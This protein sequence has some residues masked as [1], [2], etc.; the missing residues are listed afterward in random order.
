MN[1][2]RDAILQFRGIVKEFPGVK[3]LKGIDLDLYEG[4]V[5]VLVGANGAGKSTLVK[6]L[7]GVYQPDAGE[8]ILD[9]KPVTMKNPEVALALG[10]SIVYQNFNL[11]SKMDVGQNIFLTREPLKG[12][13]IKRIDWDRIYSETE[14]I[15]RRLNLNIDGRTKVKELS[16]ADL[17]MIEIAK[18]LSVKSRILVLDEPTS[19]LSTQEINELFNRIS[20]LRSEG[21][22]ILYI[23]HRLEEIKQI[24]DRVSVFRDGE[25]VGTGT[26]K[27]M[28]LKKIIKMMI[29]REI[30]NIYPW[31]SR[32]LGEEI[33]AIEK[34]T[35]PG[36]FREISFTLRRGEIL[37]ITGL[38]GAKRTELAHAIFGALSI[39]SGRVLVEGRVVH[40]RSPG[41]A[42]DVGIG[43]LPEDKEKY[44]LFSIK[45]VANNITSAGLKF[46]KKPLGLDLIQEK[47]LAEEYVDRLHIQTP[48]LNTQ[49]KSLSGGN[50][51][52]VML[53]K[54][55]FTNSRIL[56]FD[57]PTKGID[58][59][60]KEEVYNLMA[61]LAN[62][63]KAIIMISSEVLEIL[64][65]SDRILVMKAGRITAEMSR[66]EANQ[67]KI[68][69]AA[70]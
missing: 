51:Q 33:L 35:S 57:E 22:A 30:E 59:G 34:L 24:A 13:V 65:M 6:I 66:E 3:A 53:A 47:Q 44:G 20:M 21:V 37:G 12:K 4:E 27:E 48:S 49:I 2:T 25:K 56:I 45:S 63:G 41:K 23:S 1:R 17:Q 58:V 54:S 16:V 19:A 9:G 32:P 42:I 61:E 36:T 39:D 38:V 5:H 11:I 62:E 31:K 43:L 50:Q 10:V 26:I 67:S 40:M 7:A 46:L 15:L 14:S 18:A 8:I 69:E 64:G 60:A 70:L 68:L 52:K 28:D 29:G 55:L